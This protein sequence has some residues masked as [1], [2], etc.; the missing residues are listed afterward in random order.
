MMTITKLPIFVKNTIYGIIS[1]LVGVVSSLG[2]ININISLLDPKDL[3][4]LVS[5]LTKD[6]EFQIK[7]LLFLSMIT[8]KL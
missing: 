5:M 1:M 6:K 4:Q 2:L 8:R 3:I 7:L